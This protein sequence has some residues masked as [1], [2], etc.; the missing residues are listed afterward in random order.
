M[1]FEDGGSERLAVSFKG[2]GTCALQ[3]W[4]DDSKDVVSGALQESLLN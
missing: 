2:V 4:R 1:G 3:G